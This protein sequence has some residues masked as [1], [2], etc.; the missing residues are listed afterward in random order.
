MSGPMSTRTQTERHILATSGGS[1]GEPRGTYFNCDLS[2]NETHHPTTTLEIDNL[3]VHAS[4]AEHDTLTVLC[5]MTATDARLK[6][7]AVFEQ[8]LTKRFEHAGASAVDMMM[9]TYYSPNDNEVEAR[10][11]SA[12]IIYVSGGTS[13]LLVPTLRRRRVDELLAAAAERGTILTGLSAGLCCWFSRTNSHVTPDHVT[14]TDGLGWFDALVAPHWD[15]APKRHKPFHRYLLDHPGVVGLAFDEHTAIEIRGDMFRLH[16][17]STGGQVHRGHY[18]EAT[19]H[20]SFEP[21][22]TSW[23]FAPL[24]SL[25]IGCT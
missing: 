2:D 12:D 9:L 1:F 13:H 17:F 15:I 8:A 6:N 22:N 18:C 16:E 10:I 5:I 20:Y 25:G 14:T 23:E 21:V 11:E 4:R 24:S 7:V 3:L 19:G